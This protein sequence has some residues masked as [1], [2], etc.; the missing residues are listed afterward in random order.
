MASF[1]TPSLVH[2]V[3]DIIGD[4]PVEAG[5]VQETVTYPL[6]ATAVTAVGAPGTPSVVPELIA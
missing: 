4:P 3:Y 1:V 5:A 2:T 6:V